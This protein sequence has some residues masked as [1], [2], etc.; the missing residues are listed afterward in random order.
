MVKSP[1]E[2]LKDHLSEIEALTSELKTMEDENKDLRNRISNYKIDD[3]N[4]EFTRDEF[5]LKM[6]KEFGQKYGIEE[7]KLKNMKSFA[8]LYNKMQ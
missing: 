8:D 5:E 3:I 1:Q 7:E 4:Y 6:I 2:I